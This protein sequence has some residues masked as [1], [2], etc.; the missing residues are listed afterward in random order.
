[1]SL[2]VIRSL[3]NN[4]KLLQRYRSAGNIKKKA[5]KLDSERQNFRLHS[6][7]SAVSTENR[8]D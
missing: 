6:K 8:I 3:K 7:L 5:D 2:E 4:K 1:M